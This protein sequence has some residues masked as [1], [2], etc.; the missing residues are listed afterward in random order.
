M[1]G[2]TIIMGSAEWQLC[3]VQVSTGQHLACPGSLMAWWFLGPEVS[4]TGNRKGRCVCC[5]QL[6]AEV[7]AGTMVADR[8][9]SN[10]PT[11][12]Q[13]SHFL[14]CL[15]RSLLAPSFAHQLLW[16]C[17]VDIFIH[18]HG[19]LGLV[20]WCL[21]LPSLTLWFIVQGQLSSQKREQ[22]QSSELKESR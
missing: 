7:Q 2:R 10:S 21:H 4:T 17:L 16:A 19:F 22:I 12:S 18:H 3:L 9:W 5:I 15:P 13:L 14:F 6:R 11:S 1:W 20:L 8:I